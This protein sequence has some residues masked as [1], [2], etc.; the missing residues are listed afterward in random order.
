MQESMI[1]EGMFVLF[2]L[3]RIIFLHL[4]MKSIFF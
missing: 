4:N 2:S 3:G 1:Y